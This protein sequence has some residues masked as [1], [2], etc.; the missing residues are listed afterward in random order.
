MHVALRFN[1]LDITID[2]C[3]C[4]VYKSIV[5]VFACKSS[6]QLLHLFSVRA[7]TDTNL[8]LSSRLQGGW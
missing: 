8:A 1:K 6:S 5:C 4:C 7:P 2:V 3:I